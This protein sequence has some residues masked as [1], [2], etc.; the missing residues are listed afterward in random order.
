VDY[1]FVREYGEHPIVEDLGAYRSLFRRVVMLDPTDDERGAAASVLARV[2]NEADYWGEKAHMAG[3]MGG[4]WV[5]DEDDLP[6][7][8]AIAMAGQKD[9]SKIVVVGDYLWAT[10]Q[11]TTARGGLLGLGGLQFQ[12]NGLLFR[13]AMFWLNDN[14]Q[15]IAVPPEALRVA[16]IGTMSDSAMWSWRAV[17]IA[18]LPLACLLAGGVVFLFRRA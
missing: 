2:P 12:G 11:I 9:D 4:A 13:N 10:D 7:G 5:K 15:M 6:G 17:A 14:E 1:V 8:F 16:R 3:S 18:G